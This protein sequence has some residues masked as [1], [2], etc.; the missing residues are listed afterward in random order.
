VIVRRKGLLNFHPKGGQ[1]GGKKKRKKQAESATRS[2]MW[3]VVQRNYI[4]K[5]MAKAVERDIRREKGIGN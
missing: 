5:I 2:Q 4:R 1:R 3:P